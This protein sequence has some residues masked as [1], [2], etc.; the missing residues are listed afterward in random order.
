MRMELV[1]EC[2]AGTDVAWFCVRAQPKGESLAARLLA[3]LPGLEV[4]LPRIKY[5]R[6]GRTGTR[7]VTEAL[8]PGYLFAKF[9]LRKSLRT[10]HYC[11]GVSCVVHFGSH[12][13]TVPERVVEEIH[14]ALGEEEIK[15]IGQVVRPGDEVEIL[16]GPLLGLT[17]VV[18]RFMP[19]RQRVAVLLE[20]LG[21]QSSVELPF[22]DV[23]SQR[24]VRLQAG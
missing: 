11:P 13:P 10:I 17:A 22:S 18:E 20:F 9:D 16:T 12:W 4:F 3:G 15:T 8:F 5:S 24:D 23:R 2:T 7:W 14:R 21:R 19:A 6:A 1:E